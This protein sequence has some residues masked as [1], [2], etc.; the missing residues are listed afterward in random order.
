M[1]VTH[2][3]DHSTPSSATFTVPIYNVEVT[4]SVSDELPQVTKGWPSKEDKEF[5]EESDAATFLNR[6]KVLVAFHRGIVMH[7]VIAH[8]LFH[9]T[10]HI[11]NRAGIRLTK[12]ND[13][14]HAYLAGFLAKE[15]YRI[16]KHITKER[17]K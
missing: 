14:A 11:L 15:A 10:H 1:I 13:E 8:E 2:Q 16:I 9:V 5:F 6:A 17:I 4:L 3:Y 7:E 12:R